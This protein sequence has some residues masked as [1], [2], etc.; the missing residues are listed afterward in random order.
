MTFAVI[1]GVF[2]YPHA[3]SPILDNINL[4]VGEGELLAVLGPNGAGKTTLMRTMIGLL[5]WSSGRTEVDGVDLRAMTQ[6]EVGRTIAYVPQARSAVTLS[7]TGLDMV[8]LG[9]A[10]HLG[11]F[12]QPGR[13]ERTLAQRTLASIG[14]DHLAE[15]PCGTMS[16]GQFQMVLIARALISEPRILVLDEPET[17]L[18]FHNQLVVLKL[19]HRLVREKRLTVVM[20]THYPAHALR[21]ADKVILVDSA[22]RPTSGSV[23]EVMTEQRLGEVFDVD[24]RISG[25]D[26]ADR[27][28][29]T[30]TA[31]DVRR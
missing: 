30:V 10:P 7:L 20:N 8:T 1:D 5:P 11:L 2:R 27:Q 12:A 23:A 13:T 18:D 22:H 24:V 17:G 31:M 6:R 21:I 19:L 25:I 16:G 28:I 3:G 9:R 26:Y 14:A 4:S 29:P 15:M